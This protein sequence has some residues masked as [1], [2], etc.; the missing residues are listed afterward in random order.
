MAPGECDACQEPSKLARTRLQI[1][2]GFRVWQWDLCPTCSDI[3][4][5]WNKGG[6]LPR[7]EQLVS[8]MAAHRREA[9]DGGPGG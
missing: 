5:L 4:E 1:S 9:V 7:D 8:R 6:G 3:V 2:Q